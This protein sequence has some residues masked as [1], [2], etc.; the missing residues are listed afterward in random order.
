M[1]AV[2]AYRRPTHALARIAIV[3]AAMVAAPAHG[4]DAITVALD[5]AT[6]T[7]L[8]ERVATVVVG[9]PLIADVTVQSGG[10]LVVTGKGYGTTNLIALDRGGAILTERNIE[11]VSPLDNIVIVYR[12]ANRESYTCAP[13]CQNRITLGDSPDYFDRTLGQ[14]GN[15]AARAAAQA[16]GTTK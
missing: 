10:L 3:L 4:A 1:T 2:Y 14:S 12:G 7:K 11:V 8:P 5:Q 9:N 15:R 13:D 16:G 6:I